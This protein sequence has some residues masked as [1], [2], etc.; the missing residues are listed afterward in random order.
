MVGNEAV[1]EALGRMTKR[2]AAALL[3]EVF[4]DVAWPE[5]R[6]V[7]RDLAEEVTGVS[8]RGAREFLGKLGVWLTT[9][10]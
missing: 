5:V 9:S 10:S 6:E 4:A 2:E 8:R 7:A 1:M 3:D